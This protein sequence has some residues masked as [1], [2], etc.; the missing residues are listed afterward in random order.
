M[1]EADIAPGD[2]GRQRPLPSGHRAA[3][4]PRVW[5]LL[6]IVVLL[7]FG[8]AAEVP[9]LV[10]ALWGIALLRGMAWR[11]RAVQL[12][13]A[14]FAAYWIPE[15]LSAPDSW[16]ARKSWL[17][18]AADLRFG[19]LLLFAAAT[20]RDAARVRFVGGGIAFVLLA[21]CLDAL[22]QAA[23]GVSLGGAAQ[24]DRLS[25]IF[26]DDNLKLG[27]VVAVLAPFALLQ[28][29]PA[30][31]SKSH[32]FTVLKVAVVLA[33]VTSVVL[34]A[35]ARAAWIALAVGVACVAWR[36]LGARRG[37]LALAAV[38]GLA[39]VGGFAANEW[40]PRFAERM[41]RTAAAWRGDGAAL[42][43]AL[44]FRL[45]IWRSALAMAAAHPFNGVGVRAF[46]EAYADFAPPDD[47]WL[48]PN[49]GSGALHAHQLVL[50]LLSET[51]VTGLLCWLAGLAVALKAWRSASG[52][53]RERAA[54]PAYALAAML[55]PVNT[56]YAMYSTFWSLLLFTL[57]ALWIAALHGDEA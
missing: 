57:L 17:E 32:G 45:P 11:A 37:S 34:L 29:W 27:G 30:E 41:D 28:A 23:T 22:V 40:S 26:G 5:V 43:Y 48:D 53:A 56:H 33:L 8:A 24:A 38:V 35:G 3:R 47:H 21:W 54:A 52:T 4:D 39:I 18:V 1:S 42:D 7:P 49:H 16:D 31:P 14:L 9:V 55:F 6:A 10:G 2:L 36:R 15:L 44:S 50:E 12:A 13:L 51:G 20:L 25:G 46:R 19:F